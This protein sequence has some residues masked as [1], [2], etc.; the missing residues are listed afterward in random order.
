MIKIIIVEDE[1]SW[2]KDYEKIVNDVLF[3]SDQDY[4][5]HS[6]TKY[7]EELKKLILDNSEPKIYIMDLQVD[8]KHDGMD[9]LREIREKDWDS[10]I[11]VITNH[12]R[13]FE[14][15]HK[16]IY[17]IFD[18]IEKFNDYDKRLRRDIKRIISRKNDT[19]KFIYNS[20]KISLQIF[21]KDIQ[22]IYRDT[23]D[24]KIVIKT[25]H[26]EFMLSMGIMEIL[27]RLDGRFTQCHKSCIINNDRIEKKDYVKGFFIT[28]TGEKV[29]L[30]S[31]RYKEA[32]V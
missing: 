31:K 9:I 30:L 1:V 27:N 32:K 15:V 19:G 13:M 17:N 3:K 2:S 22:Y 5:I 25:T 14:T 12:D 16:E 24:R 8:K 4:E 10:E 26:N 20:R 23:V 28:D 7:T 18:F 11:I 29:T 21:L 6:F